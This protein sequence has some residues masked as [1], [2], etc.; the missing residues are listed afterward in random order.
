[1]IINTRYICRNINEVMAV[2]SYL[3]IEKIDTWVRTFE[4]LQKYSDHLSINH[5]A[6]NSFTQ[7]IA[8]CKQCGN[9]KTCSI[10]NYDIV[11]ANTL[12]REQKLKRI[13]K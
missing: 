13:L 12:M 9:Y 8:E 5:L 10:K 1:M 7:C 6:V 4:T 2:C 3:K 11:N